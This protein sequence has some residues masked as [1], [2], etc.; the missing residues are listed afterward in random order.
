MDMA[1]NSLFSSVEWLRNFQNIIEKEGVQWKAPSVGLDEED[2]SV[3]N[4]CNKNKML[5][6]Y[7]S[8]GSPWYLKSWGANPN[9]EMEDGDVVPENYLSIYNWLIK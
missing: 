9:T 4:F 1:M 7:F 2:E 6:I 3:F 8:A 5:S